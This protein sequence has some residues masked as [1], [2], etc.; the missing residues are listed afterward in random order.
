[1]LV[2]LEVAM[3]QEQIIA[4]VARVVKTAIREMEAVVLF[5][6]G[7][8]LH[9][10]QRWMPLGTS[11]HQMSMSVLSGRSYPGDPVSKRGNWPTNPRL[12]WRSCRAGTDLG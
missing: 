11:G 7:T 3:R 9:L 5:V 12:D 4:A 10:L 2:L 6:R 1:M 8:A